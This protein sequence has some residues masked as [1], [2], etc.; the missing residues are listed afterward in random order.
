MTA[1]T[2]YEYNTI[3]KLECDDVFSRLH[4][5]CYRSFVCVS[6]RVKLSEAMAPDPQSTCHGAKNQY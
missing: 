2:V 1:E 3:A 5:L 6:A 4:I